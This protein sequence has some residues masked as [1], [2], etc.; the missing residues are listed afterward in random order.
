MPGRKLDTNRISYSRRTLNPLAYLDHNKFQQNSHC[1]Q[2]I[3]TD[4]KNRDGEGDYDDN[5]GYEDDVIEC[6]EDNVVDDEDLPS[7]VS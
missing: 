7:S 3:P 4:I 1:H 6:D 2:K 5:D